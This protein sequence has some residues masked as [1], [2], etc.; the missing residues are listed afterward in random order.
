MKTVLKG[1]VLVL[2]IMCTAI[3][4]AQTV[5]LN[6]PDYNKPALFADVPEKMAVSVAELE[7]LLAQPV[8]TAIS[9]QLT[10][11][12]FL[13]GSVVSVSSPSNQSAKTVVIRAAN[14]LGAGLTITRITKEDG[15]FQYIG[16]LISFRHR[17]AFQLMHE[18]GGYV[19]QKK[20]VYDLMSE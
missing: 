18:E 8:G 4:R 15:S 16:R 2:C 6:E 5:P 20:H 7:L 14:R 1:A 13:T 12:L 3:A 17:D 10:S 9:T 11:S 19:L